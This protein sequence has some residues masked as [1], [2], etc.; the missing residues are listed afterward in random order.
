MTSEYKEE[1]LKQVSQ[2][3]DAVPYGKIIVELRGENSPVDVVIENRTR[4]TPKKN[5]SI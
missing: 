5:K 1:I 3:L 2:A 4:Y